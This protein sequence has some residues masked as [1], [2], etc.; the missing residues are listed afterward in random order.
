MTKCQPL[1]EVDHGLAKTP[2][3]PGQNHLQPDEWRMTFLECRWRDKVAQAGR[4]DVGCALN[5]KNT[6]P[7]PAAPRPPL[8]ESL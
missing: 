6:P 5:G 4:P 8:D 1:C 7:G 3:R 2:R